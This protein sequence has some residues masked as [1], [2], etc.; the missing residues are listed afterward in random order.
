MNSVIENL[1]I[2][3]TKGREIGQNGF[4]SQVFEAVEV[5]LGRTIAIK[6]ILKKELKIN[7]YEEA[8]LLNESQ[9]PNVVTMH[10]AGEGKA[11]D[12]NGIECEYVYLAMPL[13]KNGSL[14]EIIK[15]ETTLIQLFK[16]VFGILNGMLH[17][18][19]KGILHLDLKPDNI[20]ISDKFE[21]LITDFGVATQFDID[22]SFTK[23]KKNLFLFLNAPETVAN[24]D[25]AIQSDIYQIGILL[26]ILFNKFDLKILQKKFD[27]S[28]AETRKEN[29]LKIKEAIQKDELYP[30][31]FAE[32]IPNKVK[33]IILK[34]MK[35]NPNDRYKSVEEVRNDFASIDENDKRLLWQYKIDNSEKIWTRAID[36]KIESCILKSTGEVSYKIYKDGQLISENIIT[37]NLNNFF[38][39]V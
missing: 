32:H 4:N 15:Q 23:N 3:F 19:T 28:I 17:I 34:C 24:K 13:Y 7:Y 30:K 10:Y 27:L 31:D 18:H 37:K 29:I 9:H 11:F 5:K 35:T 26:Y 36:S 14:Q 6:K 25:V 2:Q 20:L 1:T 21:A 38:N 33:D 8:V 12:E 22:T 16:Y 39:D